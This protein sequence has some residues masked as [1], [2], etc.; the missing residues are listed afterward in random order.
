MSVNI[1]Q[2]YMSLVKTYMSVSAIKKLVIKMTW[3]ER[4]EGLIEDSDTTVQALAEYIG[5]TAKQVTRWKQ[6]KSEMGI[7]KLQKVSLYFGVSADYI[8]GLPKGLRW[9]R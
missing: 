6:G 2:T 4:L 9:P 3:N 8:L 5:V 1:I 7:E